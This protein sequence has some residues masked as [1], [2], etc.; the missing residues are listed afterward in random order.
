MYHKGLF[1]P[2]E[3]DF[4]HC[5]WYIVKYN[6]QRSCW[7]SHKLPTEDYNID[8]PDSEV[9]DQS[10][11]GPIDDGKDSSDE[12]ED[13]KSEAHPESID[14]KIPTWEEEKSKRQLEKLAEYIPTLSRPR[15]H[16]TTS[17]IP[18]IT[19]VM[20]MQ[21]TTELVQAFAT[22]EGMSSVHKGGGPPDDESHPGWFGGS[23]F[24]Y[25]APSGSG[26]GRGGRGGGG[27][28]GGGP[29]AAAVRRD[30][31]DQ[32]NSTKLSGKEPVIFNGDCSKEEAFLLEWAIYMMLNGD[33]DIMKQPFSWTMLFLTFVKGPNIQE[34]VGMQV[35]WLGRW[36]QAGARKTEEHLYNTVMD[37]FNTALS[38]NGLGMLT[39]Q[40]W[41]RLVS[42]N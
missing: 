40:L 29:A 15:S 3:F 17:R 11:W 20:A 36:L 28:G 42:S 39:I 30:P 38:Q 14:I 1:V 2:V 12:D 24:P 33:Q 6:N 4:I 31:D 23:G 32:S 10:K 5:F 22:E 21:T 37:S 34:W 7:V 18:P 19:T 26:G 16:T 13:N 8:I 41:L 27:D 35:V 9:T 25:R